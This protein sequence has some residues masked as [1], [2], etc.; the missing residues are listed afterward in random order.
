MDLVG[1]SVLGLNFLFQ[2]HL[3]YNCDDLVSMPLI[4]ALRVQRGEPDQIRS[5]RFDEAF[6]YNISLT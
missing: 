2:Q 6:L 4:D 3:V 5:E 1:P